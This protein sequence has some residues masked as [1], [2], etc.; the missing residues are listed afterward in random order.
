MRPYQQCTDNIKQ[1]GYPSH[2][3]RHHTHI[4]DS[5]LCLPPAA[6]SGS[7]PSPPLQ[8]LLQPT[9]GS[10]WHVSHTACLRRPRGSPGSGHRHSG[11]GS[12]TVQGLLWAAASG[13]GGC[14]VDYIIGLG[15]GGTVHSRLARRGGWIVEREYIHVGCVLGFGFGSRGCAMDPMGG[16]VRNEPVVLTADRLRV[17]ERRLTRGKRCTGASVS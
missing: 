7:I 6:A 17:R 4:H 16:W 2:H 3:Q 8:L 10:V 15:G 5:Y 1:L 12:S 11:S 14:G 9:A 13:R